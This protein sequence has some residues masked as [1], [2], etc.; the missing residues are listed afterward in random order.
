LKSLKLIAVSSE[1]YLVLKSL[2]S[3]GDSFNDVIT[4]V[5]KKIGVVYVPG[6]LAG[7]T[8]Q[9]HQHQ[10]LPPIRDTIGGNISNGIQ[11]HRRN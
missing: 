3:A 11:Q 6:A 1:N 9:K 10:T 2:G 8:E 7:P 5:L 4:E